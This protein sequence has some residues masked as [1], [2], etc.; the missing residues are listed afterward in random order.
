MPRKIG[1]LVCDNDACRIFVSYW[2]DAII[3]WTVC[4]Q[5]GVRCPS[6][7]IQ[8]KTDEKDQVS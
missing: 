7:Q 3:G 1:G 2:D 5:D 8:K 4:T 6:C